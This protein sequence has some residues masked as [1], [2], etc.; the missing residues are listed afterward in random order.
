MRDQKML[1]SFLNGFFA[2]S[3]VIGIGLPSLIATKDV[4]S[5]SKSAIN[6]CNINGH[7]RLF[8]EKSSKRDTIKI[9]VPNKDND[10]FYVSL[11]IL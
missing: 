3:S 6:T 2:I 8:K 7:D 4:G 1:R 11:K 5:H 9:T 10:F